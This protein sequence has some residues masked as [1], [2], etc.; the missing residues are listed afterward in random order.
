MREVE[1]RGVRYRSVTEAARALG[2]A[3][4]TV[5]RACAEGRLAT[6]GLGAPAE[7][8]RRQARVIADQAR[9]IEELT[10]TLARY[11]NQGEKP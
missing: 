6:V 2:L 7:G 10:R 8:E 5:D 11:E 1:I 9:R 4:K 3:R